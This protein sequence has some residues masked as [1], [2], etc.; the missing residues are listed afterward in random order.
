M[1][2]L[3]GRILHTK[4]DQQRPAPVS[5]VLLLNNVSGSKEKAA[6]DIYNK[7]GTVHRSRYEWV[8][9]PS[10]SKLTTSLV[11]DS[12]KVTSSDTQIY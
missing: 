1:A 12:L 10:C 8:S 7:G 11:N 2:K 6:C 3:A 9:G 5:L 4:P